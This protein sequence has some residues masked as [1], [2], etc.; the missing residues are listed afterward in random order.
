MFRCDGAARP[1]PTRP[2]ADPA[3]HLSVRSSA[4]V[5]SHNFHGNQSYFRCCVHVET[6][7]QALER[8]YF[9]VATSPD[10][11]SRW[12]ADLRALAALEDPAPAPSPAAEPPAVKTSPV[13]PTL[14]PPAVKTR[15]RSASKPRTREPASSSSRPS[16]FDV[17]EDMREVLLSPG[18]TAPPTPVLITAPSRAFADASPADASPSSASTGGSTPRSASASSVR[19]GASRARSARAGSASGSG[20]GSGSESRPAASGPAAWFV[21]SNARLASSFASVAEEFSRSN[22]QA[23]AQMLRASEM[24]REAMDA[25]DDAMAATRRL[26]E[27]E[28]TVAREARGRADALQER[29]EEKAAALE[30]TRSDLARSAKELA[31]AREALATQREESARAAAVEREIRGSLAA[32]ERRVEALAA[33]RTAAAAE[34][35]RLAAQLRRDLEEAGERALRAAADAQRAV[36]EERDKVAVLEEEL[37]RRRGI[38]ALFAKAPGRGKTPTP[39]GGSRFTGR[40]GD[41]ASRGVESSARGS[42]PGSASSASVT[43]PLLGNGGA[44]PEVTPAAAPRRLFEHGTAPASPAEV[45]DHL[46]SPGAH[47]CRQM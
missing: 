27:A 43:E 5:S 7:G 36:E 19:S 26:L 46:D 44:T 40:I 30:K 23:R 11:A 29:L 39:T 15:P 32:A 47:G 12:V 8:G 10:E 18:L 41:R 6:R 35:H 4:N 37:R 38:R 24:T 31:H 21:G 20:S 3:P 45:I 14:T 1:G 25:K 2:R 42:A 16:R 22:D 34:A 28:A 33:E 9:L 13:T 17:A